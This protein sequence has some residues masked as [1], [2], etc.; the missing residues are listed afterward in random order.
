MYTYSLTLKFLNLPGFVTVEDI[1]M[2]SVFINNN[3]TKTKNLTFA[4]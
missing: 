1:K 4:T 2:F 3:F